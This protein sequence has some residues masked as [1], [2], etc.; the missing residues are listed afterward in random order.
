MPLPQERFQT[1]YKQSFMSISNFAIHA[2][3]RKDFPCATAG[4]ARRTGLLSTSARTALRTGRRNNRPFRVPARLGQSLADRD[5]TLVPHHEKKLDPN[6]RTEGPHVSFDF[7]GSLALHWPSS[8][9]EK[10]PDPNAGSRAHHIHRSLGAAWPH[11]GFILETGKNSIPATRALSVLQR[12]RFCGI[13]NVN[14]LPFPSSLSTQIVPPCSSTNRFV[15]ARPS[16]V[17]SYRRA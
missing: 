5:Q 13:V 15:N 8:D 9:K 4:S 17:P 6:I 7:P 2:E 11:P 1:I 14:V 12:Y 16:P 10:T 3:S